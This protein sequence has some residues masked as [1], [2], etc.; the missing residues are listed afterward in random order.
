MKGILHFICSYPY[1]T[2]SRISLDYLK[3]LT[4]LHTILNPTVPDVAQ[5]THF[6]VYN[7]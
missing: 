2:S 7:Q 5:Y 3:F 4:L 1:A 6:F